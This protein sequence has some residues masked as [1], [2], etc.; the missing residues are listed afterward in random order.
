MQ[1]LSQSLLEKIHVYG[2]AEANWKL[3][4]HKWQ[5]WKLFPVMT[6]KQWHKVGFRRPGQEVDSAPLSRIFPKWK[7]LTQV[8][9]SVIFKVN[10]KEKKMVLSLFL[11]SYIFCFKSLHR[12]TQP[13]E[14]LL[15]LLAYILH[16]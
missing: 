2:Y 7:W 1:K 15:T 14:L 5:D 4:S 6:V 8:L 13:Y 12:F 10:S 16:Q 11:F 3:N 9:I